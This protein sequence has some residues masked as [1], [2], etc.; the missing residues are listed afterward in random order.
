MKTLNFSGNP[1]FGQLEKLYDDNANFKEGIKVIFDN[2]MYLYLLRKY[3]FK[4]K[5]VKTN[6]L[7]GVLYLP[8]GREHSSFIQ[9]KDHSFKVSSYYK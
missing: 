1:D 2:G 9:Q 4:G 3:T 5:V 8:D 6:Y 7:H